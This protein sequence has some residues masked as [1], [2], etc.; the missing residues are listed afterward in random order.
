[1]SN[2][3]GFNLSNI[4][5]KYAIVE[6]MDQVPDI[7]NVEIKP[8]VD[9]MEP[10]VEI[11]PFVDVMDPMDSE[12]PMIN[13][14]DP[15]N[16]TTV[17]EQPTMDFVDPSQP[18]QSEFNDL[19][20]TNSPDMVADY[21]PEMTGPVI[22]TADIKV[23]DQGCPNNYPY[24]THQLAHKNTNYQLCFSDPLCALKDENN[25]PI[26]NCESDQQLWTNAYEK[27]ADLVWPPEKKEMKLSLGGLKDS[28]ELSNNAEN[29]YNTA[30]VEANNAMNNLTNVKS[31]YEKIL[32]EKDELEKEI[33]GL[34]NEMAQKAANVISAEKNKMEAD[35]T[36]NEKAKELTESD[37]STNYFMIIMVFI[38][39][40]LIIGGA[41]WYYTSYLEKPVAKPVATPPTNPPAPVPI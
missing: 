29:N 40:C 24:R 9:V 26:K 41:Y 13:P 19:A 12:T 3:S 22:D 6:N 23:N 32:N 8:F 37:E 14:S 39:I 21:T 25:E 35:K 7:E 4:S 1:M 20:T 36:T 27:P 17:N 28:I 31:N 10:G 18:S 11:K 38:L 2:L 34:E 33:K 5:L 15:T 16:P 30:K